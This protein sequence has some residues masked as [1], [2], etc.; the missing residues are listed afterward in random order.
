MKATG[1]SAWLHAGTCIAICGVLLIGR[2]NAMWA[3]ITDEE[4][5]ASA[6]LI[7]VGE[8]RTAQHG[9]QGRVAVS[10]VLKGKKTLTSIRV[11]SAAN[12]VAHSSTDLVFHAGDRGIW[13]LRR[14]PGLTDVY[15]I[16]HP[17]RFVP[18]HGGEE[19]IQALRRLLKD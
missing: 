14:A 16:D 1:V 5:V 2:A 19:R 18:S 6:D 17:Q 4:L 10:E 9:E 8:W 11:E 7:V 13:L 3:P 12:K 15:L